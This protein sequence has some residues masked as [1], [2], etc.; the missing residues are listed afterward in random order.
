MTISHS[1][2]RSL[3]YFGKTLLVNK[4]SFP[5]TATLLQTNI[6][7]TGTPGDDWLSRA[8]QKWGKT[9][10]LSGSSAMNRGTLSDRHSITEIVGSTSPLFDDS[11]RAIANASPTDL[12][13]WNIGI[14]SAGQGNVTDGVYYEVDIIYKVQAYGYRPDQPLTLPPER[15]RSGIKKTPFGVQ[16]WTRT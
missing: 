1:N 15:V 5:I 14:D 13:W 2:F 8:G 16:T 10:T 6:T 7:P 11:F 9:I 4:Q 12:T 3:G